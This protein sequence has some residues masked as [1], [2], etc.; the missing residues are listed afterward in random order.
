MLISDGPLRWALREPGRTAIAAGDRMLTYGALAARAGAVGAGVAAM[1]GTERQQPVALRLPDPL[2]F[3]PAFLGVAAA[4]A[5]AV[6]FDPRWGRRQAESAE[7]SCPPALR[8]GPPPPGSVHSWQSL[9]EVEAAGA[10]G[11]PPGAAGATS[12]SLFYAGFSS[13][14]SGRP[15][16]I[17]RTHAAWLNSFLAMGVEFGIG[18]GTAVAVT[19]PLASSFSLIAALQALFVGATL[20]LPAGQGAGPILHCLQGEGTVV[21]ALPST[22]QA[23]TGHAGR[24]GRQLPGVCRIVCAGE[25]L[26][27]GTRDAAARIFPCAEVVEYY[28]ASELG[29]VTVCRG[30]DAIAHPGSVGRPFPGSEV[31]ILDASGR[32]LPAG[33]TGLLCARTEYGFAGYWGDERG[34]DAIAHHGWQTVRDLA[35][36]DADGFV[37]LTGRADAM[38]VVRGRNV[39]PEATERVILA[40]PGVAEAA[41]VGEPAGKPTHLVA[42]VRAEGEVTSAAVVAACHAELPPAQ[43]PRRVQFVEA[44][45]HTPNGKLDRTRLPALVA[46]RQGR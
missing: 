20:L 33:E 24:R 22:L 26:P 3:L 44:L 12:A 5:I 14:S 6:P 45:P 37:Y 42:L 10:A 30:T 43:A 15:K 41:V 23:L 2:A 40:I 11:G 13:G 34:A 1:L 25:Q 7:S 35:R 27:G 17:A 8:I 31:A 36:Q 19:G 9:V 29:F 4:G 32:P 28:G 21:Y 38:L 18:S 16:A 46:R 39:F